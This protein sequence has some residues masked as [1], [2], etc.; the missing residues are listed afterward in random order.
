MDFKELSTKKKLMIAGLIVL[1]IVIL[2]I[3]MARSSDAKTHAKQARTAADQAQF[4]A[5]K[6]TEQSNIAKIHANNATA[7][8]NGTTPKPPT[9]TPKPPTTISKPPEANGATG[10]FFNGQ[11]GGFLDTNSGEKAPK[12]P[13]TTP[14]PPVKPAQP[15]GP[16][17]VYVLNGSSMGDLLGTS[18]NGAVSINTP[19]DNIGFYI[20]NDSKTTITSTI[21]SSTQFNGATGV[22]AYSSV[23]G[24]PWET[25]YNDFTTDISVAPGQGLIINATQLGGMSSISFIFA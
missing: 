17:R 6:A 15:P 13:V 25:F 22:W 1:I 21:V 2:I 11:T 8:A 12:P 4:H 3:V 20:K 7:T 24:A 23:S 5:N 16:V 9:T 19:Q 10:S 14:K 18:V